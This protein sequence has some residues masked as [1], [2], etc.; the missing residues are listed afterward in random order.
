MYRAF[1]QAFDIKVEKFR[2]KKK[3]KSLIPFFSCSKSELLPFKFQ[4]NEDFF[5]LSLFVFH[6]L[7]LSPSSSL[8][9]SRRKMFKTGEFKRKNFLIGKYF[10]FF[11]KLDRESKEEEWQEKKIVEN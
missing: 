9:Y 3:K 4:H 2:V 8:L 6:S 5:S 10:R 7:C 11:S 1:A